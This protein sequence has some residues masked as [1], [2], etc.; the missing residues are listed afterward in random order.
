MHARPGLK[1]CLGVVGDVKE[2]DIRAT[3]L[4]VYSG[5]RDSDGSIQDLY[6]FDIACGSEC[7]DTLV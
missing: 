3:C 6:V 7:L 4:E 5:C 1:E 2:E